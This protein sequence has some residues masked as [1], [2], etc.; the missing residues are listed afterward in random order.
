MADLLIPTDRGLYCPAGNF[1][2][3]PHKP[4]ELAV[5]THAHSD[6][7]RR[8]CGAYLTAA[9]GVPTLQLRVGEKARIDGLPFG[10]S[11]VHNGVRVS[12]HPA[13]HILGSAQVRIEY[14]GE[15]WV[16][17]GDYKT[18]AD[19]TCDAYE[20]VRCDTFITESTF[21][22]PIYRWRAN[23]ELVDEINAW[24]RGNVE[25]RRTSVIL[26]YSL[27]KAQRVLGM[28]DP[29]IGPILIHPAVEP[30]YRTYQQAG[31]A[32]PPAQCVDLDSARRSRGRGVLVAPSLP[33]DADWRAALGEIS[34][35]TAS[36]WMQVGSM[37]KRAGADFGFVVSDHADWEGLLSA[38]RETGATR[39]LVTHGYT[40]VL[41]RYLNEQGVQ[42]EVLHFPR[43][44]VTRSA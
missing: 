29:A 28:L 43:I 22:L 30:F 13:G 10:Q 41:S 20:P 2:V 11:I 1:Y 35:A 40:E 37:R 23:N 19:P 31:I 21:G 34:V 39:V 8:G 3:D 17:S 7:A 38:C 6:H 16:V 4:V 42:S 33:M 32:L 25:Q 18:V 44:E 9:I 24:W 12:L 36:G 26:A 14:R 15:V 5:V 27:G